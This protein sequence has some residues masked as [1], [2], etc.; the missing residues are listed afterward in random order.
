MNE[1]VFRLDRYEITST[2]FEKIISN[3]NLKWEYVVKDEVVKL[4][5]ED[6]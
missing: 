4:F 6:T 2:D 3:Y 1:Y 5:F